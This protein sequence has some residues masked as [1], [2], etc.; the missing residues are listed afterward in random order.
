[1]IKISIQFFGGNGSAGKRSSSGTGAAANTA[2]VNQSYQDKLQAYQNMTNAEF[3]AYL[4]KT[5]DDSIPLPDSSYHPGIAFQR[6]VIDLG[7]NEKPDVM[8]EKTFDQMLTDN[9][10]MKV[11]YR[12]VVGNQNISANGIADQLR[13]SDGLHV[14]GGYYGDGLYFAGNYSTAYGYASNRNYS[15]TVIRAAIKPDAKIISSSDLQKEYN[16]LPTSTKQKLKKAGNKSTWGN[17]GESQL[18]LKLGYDALEGAQSN[19]LIILNRKCLVVDSTNFNV[20]T[21]NEKSQ[22]KVDKQPKQAWGNHQ[23]SSPY[24]SL[25]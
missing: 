24:D 22:G 17:D 16:K 14:G 4:D 23:Y 25:K 10:N 11:I 13:D 5:L 18:A 12:G 2:A 15:G 7:V 3:T 19:H 20:Y 6:M 1:M 9:P 21:A 8:D